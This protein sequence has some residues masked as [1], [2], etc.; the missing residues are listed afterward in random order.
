MNVWPIHKAIMAI[1]DI[2]A[3]GRDI[4]E[5]CGNLDLPPDLGNGFAASHCLNGP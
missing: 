4:L 3:E 1:K 2:Y 5:G